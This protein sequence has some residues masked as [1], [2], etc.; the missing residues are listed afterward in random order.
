VTA[1][2]T[3]LLLAV[4]AI[5]AAKPA[6]RPIA[7]TLSKPGYTVIALAANGAAH[8]VRALGGH[9]RLRPPARRVTLQLR[10]PGGTY[11]GPV[12]VG[13]EQRGKRAILGVRAGARLGRV[14]LKLGRGYAK[15][16]RRLAAKWV[17]LER[18]ARARKGVPIGAGNFGLVRST[19][20]RGGLRGDTDLD[21]VP[22]SIDVDDDGDRILDDYDRQTERNTGSGRHPRARSSLLGGT[23]PDGSHLSLSTNLWFGGSEVVN[24]NGGSTD[25]QIA[26]SQQSYGGLNVGWIGIDPGSGELDC[27]TLVYCSPEGTGRFQASNGPGGFDRATAERFPECCD[28]D[29]DGLGS[30]TQTAPPPG[31]PNP[32]G[33]DGGT[34]SLF[35]GASQDQLRTGDVLIEKATIGGEPIESTASIGF[36]FST[37]PALASYSDGQGN[38]AS[39]SY[40]LPADCG[41]APCL[42]VRAGPDGNAVVTLTVWRPQRQRLAEEPGEG[43]WMDVGN[44]TYAV[45]PGGVPS[46]GTCPQ[47]SYSGLSGDLVADPS[48]AQH[49]G[50]PTY[51]AYRFFDLAG[52]RPADP[53][54]TFSF[55]LNLSDCL[56]A[57]GRAVTTEQ[58]QGII[59]WAF[60]ETP[61][62]ISLANFPAQ[63][64]LQP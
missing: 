31:A 55:T 1:F 28:A 49:A 8:S 37:M 24:A 60:S 10:A 7:G 63:F 26:A 13:R 12:V 25:A 23:F 58:P 11:A 33:A 27:G 4:P 21:G 15:P 56:R 64:A 41:A 48:F 19:H 18:T 22:D 29:H 51:G 6:P 20:T 16:A 50:P 30:L 38:S 40:P 53:A 3:F 44:L 14:T 46:V 57:S 61:S 47:S 59:F 5:A 54:N 62:G 17:D 52:D 42:P 34:M 45:E 35:H 32:F 2:L 9:F 43:E 36:V 39:F